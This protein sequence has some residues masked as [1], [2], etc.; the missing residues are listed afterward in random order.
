M[1]K[2][3]CTAIA[4]RQWW[5]H[6]N[7]RQSKPVPALREIFTTILGM[8]QRFLACLSFSAEVISLHPK[9]L[10]HQ[11][12]G[13]AANTSLCIPAQPELTEHTLWA[14]LLASSRKE[15]HSIIPHALQ[16]TSS[17][18]RFPSRSDM[19]TWA[20]CSFK[21]LRFCFLGGREGNVSFHFF[22][23]IWVRGNYSEVP[24]RVLQ[25][26]TL[27]FPVFSQLSC[28]SNTLFK[29][30]LLLS[31]SFC[32][33][34]LIFVLLSTCLFFFNLLINTKDKIIAGKLSLWEHLW[35]QCNI[36]SCRMYSSYDNCCKGS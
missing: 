8:M 23:W 19:Q 25:G 10:A 36:F 15:L 14:S 13:G 31:S 28:L 22:K 6:C 24:Q 34:H 30:P 29:L 17:T 11:G 35:E 18:G 5:M 33:S 7:S 12:C 16:Y 32:S 1:L 9:L 4:Q 21:V 3:N 27:T 26:S 20:S 2:S